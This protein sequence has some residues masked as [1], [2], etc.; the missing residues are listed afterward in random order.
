MKLLLQAWHANGPSEWTLAAALFMGSLL[1]LIVARHIAEKVVGSMAKQQ[2]WEHLSRA[3]AAL[4]ASTR[5]WLLLP[6]SLYIGS[7]ALEL[8][9]K[10]DNT[11]TTV[12]VV[13]LLIQAAFWANAIINLWM[14]GQIEKR[15]ATDGEAVTALTLMHFVARVLVWTLIL[16][17]ILNHL[18]FNIS[19]LVTGLGVGGV[20][21]ALA[22]QNVLGDLFASLSIVLDKPFVVG[23]FI[24][25]DT[26]M[27]SVEAVGL[28]TTRVRSL[29]GELIIFSNTDLLK[30]RVRN[31]KRMYE[32][33]ATFLVNAAYGTSEENLA[34]IPA[35]LREAVMANEQVRFERA[36][37]KEFGE[38]ALVFEVAYYVLNP[39]NTLYMDIQQKIN[40]AVYREFAKRGIS[41]A[42]PTRVLRVA[43]GALPVEAHGHLL[44]EDEDSAPREANARPPR[45]GDAKQQTTG[46]RSWTKDAIA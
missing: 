43:G 19:A 34:A 7:T 15:R 36:H 21:V 37:F 26:Y 29:S 44:E 2:R 39:D 33:R 20:A 46:E 18:N 13:G 23:D 6:L 10:L 41:F 40:L 17:V 25:V 28:K 22:V 11:V 1:L 3:P 9:A 24:I 42:Q 32:R 5:Q 45:Q 30:S 16:L 38:S 35:M 31:Y 27:G 8:P 14:S 4:I 12:L